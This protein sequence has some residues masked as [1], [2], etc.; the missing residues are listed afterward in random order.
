MFDH[1]SI[2][3]M[4]L[5]VLSCILWHLQVQEDFGFD[6]LGNT[7]IAVDI[8]YADTNLRVSTLTVNSL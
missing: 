8:Y 3:K 7:H 6:Q 1:E 5:S 4:S 2:T